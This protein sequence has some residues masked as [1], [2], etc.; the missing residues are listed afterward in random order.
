MEI[1]VSDIPARDKKIASLFYS[2]CGPDL[3][4]MV[5]VHKDCREEFET[6]MTVD[7]KNNKIQKSDIVPSN[8]EILC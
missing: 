4:G 7:K 1:L 6:Y 2:V 8:F 5:Y 3:A